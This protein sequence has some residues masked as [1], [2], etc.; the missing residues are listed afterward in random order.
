M[1][2]RVEFCDEIFEEIGSLY[3][4]KSSEGSTILTN[5]DMRKKIYVILKKLVQMFK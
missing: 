2:R 3:I 5:E 4:G 1:P